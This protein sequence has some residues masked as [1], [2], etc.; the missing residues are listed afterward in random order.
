MIG[1]RDKNCL[2]FVNMCLFTWLEHLWEDP[3]FWADVYQFGFDE[4][5]DQEM[6]KSVSN[7]HQGKTSYELMMLVFG[8]KQG[9]L[10]QNTSKTPST[11]PATTSPTTPNG[12]PMAKRFS[13]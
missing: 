13:E 5:V 2:P 10:H 1:E 7:A 4:W 3:D 8:E 9:R 12:V 11:V 6:E